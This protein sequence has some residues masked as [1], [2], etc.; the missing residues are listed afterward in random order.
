MAEATPL[1][2]LELIV[3]NGPLHH[4]S[5]HEAEAILGQ[6]ITK[7]AIRI[8]RRAGWLEPDIPTDYAWCASEKGIAKIREETDEPA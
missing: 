1:E 5:F 7:D 4:E 8:C 3:D 6:R 2:V